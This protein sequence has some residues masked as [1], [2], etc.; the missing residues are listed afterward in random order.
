MDI[1]IQ[2]VEKEK[3]NE[4][5]LKFGKVFTDHMFSMEY[6]PEDGWHNA[7]IEPY[8]DLVLSP[9]CQI[10]HYGQE[11]FEGLKA[12]RGKN[13]SIHLFRPEMNGKRMES[14]CKRLCIPPVPVEDFVEAC[15]LLTQIERS[16]I[17]HKMG[18]SLYLRPFIIA[19]DVGLGVHPS[20]HYLFII[21]ASPSG[22]YYRN[23]MEPVSI[24]IEDEYVRA[25]RG[26]M[27]FAKTGGNYAASLVGQEKAYEYGYEQVLWL[28][29]VE[30]K[31]IEEVGAMN[32]AFILGDTMVTP[33]LTGSILPGVTRDSVIQLCKD[34][35]L[36]VEERR[37]SVEELVSSL[38]N[39][40]LKEA[41]G[42]GTAAVISPVGRFKYKNK[43]YLVNDGKIGPVAKKLYNT[44]LGIQNDL[45]DDPHGWRYEVVK[46]ATD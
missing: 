22:A 19:T 25:V 27:G 17:P 26:G 32:I 15:S 7:R 20:S 29:G 41:F 35:G 34:F 5:T 23:G 33:S 39:G 45:I 24:I 28:D 6:S 2:L 40:T 43:E 12:Y 10:F 4:D 1:K 13:G 16:W 38:E 44:L 30:R 18:N 11:V 21:I 46:G 42:T 36:K 9:A 3:P 8:H 37:I 31:Y 14:S